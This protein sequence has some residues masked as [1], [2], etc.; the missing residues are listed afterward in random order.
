LMVINYL[1]QAPAAAPSA[2]PQTAGGPETTLAAAAVDEA[3]VLFDVSPD[4]SVP[5]LSRVE[6]SGTSPVV[7]GD[8]S[9]TQ[10]PA[11]LMPVNVEASFASHGEESQDL[12]LADADLERLAAALVV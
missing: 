6:Q 12:L 5:Q 8:A 2:A 3:I 11:L 4:E 1:L 7:E 10:S 9:S